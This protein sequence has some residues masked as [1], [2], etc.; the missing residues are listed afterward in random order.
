MNGGS[1]TGKGFTLTK[2]ENKRLKR[3]KMNK[4]MSQKARQSTES[5]PRF[6]GTQPSSTR[7]K[8]YTKRQIDKM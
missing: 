4:S 6:H 5:E 7:D 3:L 1:A 8:V 2:E